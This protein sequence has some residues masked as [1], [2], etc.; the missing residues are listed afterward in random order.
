MESIYY[1]IYKNK[2]LTN[3]V[4]GVIIL[5][6]CYCYLISCD[7]TQD[8]KKL[9][10]DEMVSPLI[11]LVTTL[12]AINIAIF[13]RMQKWSDGLQNY[14]NVHFVHNGYVYG[15]FYECLIVGKQDIRNQSQS[16]GG[17]MF[18][19][20]LELTANNELSYLGKQLF[21]IE[22]KK[23]GPGHLW[24]YVMRL[25]SPPTIISEKQFK[26]NDDVMSDFENPYFLFTIDRDKQSTSAVKGIIFGLA[27]DEDYYKI[28]GDNKNRPKYRYVSAK[29]YAKKNPKKSCTKVY[30]NKVK[31][32]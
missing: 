16:L 27:S 2:K 26:L 23:K 28:D 13:Q 17:S 8:G 32:S 15:S 7:Y 22:G 30:P 4:V 14:L 25:N 24:E 6:L 19:E 1:F 21:D 29:S 10:W 31:S 9:W 5:L 18:D 20:R 11:T 12:I 3:I